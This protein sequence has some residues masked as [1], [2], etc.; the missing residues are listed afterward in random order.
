MLA[1]TNRPDVLDPALLR[2]GRFDR[3][4]TV[5]RPTLK[6]RL[7]IFKV[8]VRDVPLSDDVDLNRLAAATVGLTG[9]DI[10]NIVNEAAL[11]G[12]RQDKN[13]V[14]MADF[15]YARDKVLMGAKREEVLSEQGEGKDGL[16]RGGPHAD[17]LELARCPPR[18]Q[19]DHHS[20]AA[21]RSVPRTPSPRKIG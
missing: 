20:R 21:V 12:R 9:A 6:G 11:V 2:P 10:R 8:H 15:D 5:D 4:V 7:E 3:H 17:R 1:S 16:S 13:N 19:S 18:A 14:D